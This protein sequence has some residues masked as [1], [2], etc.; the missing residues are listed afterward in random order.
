MSRSRR[1]Q[2]NKSGGVMLDPCAVD[3]YVSTI[4]DGPTNDF[5]TCE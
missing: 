2:V 5:G 1:A 4:L 3:F